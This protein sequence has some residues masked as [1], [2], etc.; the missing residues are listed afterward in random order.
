SADVQADR[1]IYATCDTITS[2]AENTDGRMLTVVT[3]SGA[4][5]KTHSTSQA[6]MDVDKC[7]LIAPGICSGSRS[8]LKKNFQKFERSILLGTSSFGEGID[9]PGE[10]LSCVMIVRLPF[11]PPNHPVF[12]AKAEQLKEQGKNAFFDLSLP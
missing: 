11:Q 7:V 9:I 2:L 1:L 8:R 4:S 6:T 10:D 12:E 3:S 5:R